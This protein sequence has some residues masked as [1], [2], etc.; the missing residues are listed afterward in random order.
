MFCEKVISKA[1]ELGSK[2]K[3]LL[4]TQL[5]KAQKK[6]RLR[7]RKRLFYAHFKLKRASA[8]K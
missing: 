7:K 8:Q 1:N 4:D 3:V 2:I 6:V 5:Y